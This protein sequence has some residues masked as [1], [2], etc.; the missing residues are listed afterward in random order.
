MSVIAAPSTAVSSL[1]MSRSRLIRS[2]DRCGMRTR[3]RPRLAEGRLAGVGV[4]A[5]LADAVDV[6]GAEAAVVVAVAAAVVAAVV[7]VG[8]P[9]LVAA[10]GTL[11][12]APCSWPAAGRGLPPFLDSDILTPH[13]PGSDASWVAAKRIG[14]TLIRMR[15]FAQGW[16]TS[17]GRPR[18]P[19]FSA[20]SKATLVPL[21]FDKRYVIGPAPVRRVDGFGPAPAPR[22]ARPQPSQGGI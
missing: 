21:V 8:A 10:E 1:A 20:G 7:L 19:D 11:A 14:D 6:V 13:P 18:L 12:R 16:A 15:R 2:G 22:V 3:R 9:V 5:D 17:A 4:A